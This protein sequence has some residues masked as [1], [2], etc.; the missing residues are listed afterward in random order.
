MAEALGNDTHL[1]DTGLYGP[2]HAACYLIED[3]GEF[4]I[5]DTGTRNSLPRILET[6]AALGA[7]PEQVR[8]VMP[9]HV[10]L[11]HA[12][13]SGLLIQTCPNQVDAHG[14]MAVSR[15]GGGARAR[16]TGR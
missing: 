11:D 5:V 1:I 6:L 13:G 2:E 16:C 8:Y 4:A 3:G 10:H 9:T 14:S 12:S 15:P 7:T